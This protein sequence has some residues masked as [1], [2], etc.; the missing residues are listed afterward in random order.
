M[1]SHLMRIALFA[2]GLLGVNLVAAWSLRAQTASPKLPAEGLAG[3]DGVLVVVDLP[4]DTAA[5]LGVDQATIA[6]R[7]DRQ[8]RAA[9]VR[10][11]SREEPVRQG[12]AELR[13]SLRASNVEDPTCI[14]YSITAA[15]WEP[16]TLIRDRTKVVLASTWQSPGL[17]SAGKMPLAG[18]TLQRIDEQVDVFTR[19]YRMA[20][21]G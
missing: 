19:A 13:I 18:T 11:L 1:S 6:G 20:N 5:L 3:L 16:A 7:V 9:R 15:V 2:A 21:G 4:A 10:N 8:L 17:T 12:A 14:A